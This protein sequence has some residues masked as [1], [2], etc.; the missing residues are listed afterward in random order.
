MSVTATRVLM[1][2]GVAGLLGAT[3]APARAADAPGEIG[4]TGTGRVAIRPDLVLLQVG[5]EARTQ[6]LPGATADVARRMQAVLGAVKALG[7]DAADITTVHYALEP[8]TAPRRSED[9]PIRIA[10]YYVA[11]IVQVRVRRRDDAARVLEAAIGAGA[12]TVR[13]VRFTV[14][15]PAPAE[16]RARALAVQDALD[17]AR[18]IAQAAGV[19]LGPIVSIS[20]GG[21]PR[22]VA[23]PLTRIGV[24]AAAMAPGPMES[25]QLEITVTVDARFRLTP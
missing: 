25:G 7:I 2:L 20:E 22:P 18:Q 19:K 16:A 5:A 11:N 1:V 15:D 17:R 14:A 13:G 23:E 21:A 10:G 8:R 6:T 4:V 12:N 24:A 9:D 3:S